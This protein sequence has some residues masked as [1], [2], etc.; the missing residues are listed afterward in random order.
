M[1]ERSSSSTVEKLRLV[2]EVRCRMI[3]YFRLLVE[4]LAAG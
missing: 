1:E 2:V 3:L 4:T